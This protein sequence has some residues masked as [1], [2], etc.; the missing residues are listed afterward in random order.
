MQECCGLAMI[1]CNLGEGTRMASFAAIDM[2]PKI[3]CHWLVMFL[4][5]RGVQDNKV[6]SDL[7][8]ITSHHAIA[9]PFVPAPA[10]ENYAAGL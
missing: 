7:E 2:G 9:Q 3:G 8:T 10:I 5:L 6:A 4:V 1:V